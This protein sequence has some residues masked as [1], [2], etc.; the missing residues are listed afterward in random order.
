M[1]WVKPARRKTID[2]SGQ[3][4]LTAEA[5]EHISRSRLAF[6]FPTGTRATCRSIDRRRTSRRWVPTCADA[7]QLGGYVPQRGRDVESGSRCPRSTS[8][9]RNSTRLRRA[10]ELDDDGVRADVGGVVARQEDRQACR[11]DRARRGANVRHGRDVPPGRNLLA[12]RASST[13]RSTPTKSS[14]TG[15]R[16]KGR[17]SKKASPRQVRCRPGWPPPPR[18]ARTV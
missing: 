6:R 14:R 17:C 5:L 11:T 8:S 9:T 13:S 10:R 16:R 3:K 1:A 4:K 7:E 12:A 15:K 18:T 2:A